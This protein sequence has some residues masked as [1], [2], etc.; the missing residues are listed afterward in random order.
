MAKQADNAK[1]A[2]EE[3]ADVITISLEEWNDIQGRLAAADQGTNLAPAIEEGPHL[4][5]PD[6]RAAK[7]AQLEEF[8]DHLDGVELPDDMH[9][10][11]QEVRG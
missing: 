9:A 4:G 6:I 11:M 3:A 1:V 2:S 7:I 5:D 8:G 10:L